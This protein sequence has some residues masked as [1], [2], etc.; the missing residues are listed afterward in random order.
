MSSITK[1]YFKPNNWESINTISYNF[2]FF[3][4]FPFVF[5]Y[6]IFSLYPWLKPTVLTKKLNKISLTVLFFIFI[7]V[8][9]P[10]IRINT[11]VSFFKLTWT[12]QKYWYHLLTFINLHII[13][14]VW[15]F[16]IS[17]S[18]SLQKNSI[19]ILNTYTYS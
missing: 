13:Y 16:M 19:D 1:R 12:I 10:L 14:I 18:A 4:S 6:F 7:K 5:I 9:H 17:F 2:F 11:F 8:L 3:F 15:I